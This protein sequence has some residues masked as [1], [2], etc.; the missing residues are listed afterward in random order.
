LRKTPFFRQ[1]WAK[2]AEN[3]D[4][5]I[6]PWWVCAKIAQKIAEPILFF[7][8]Y[9]GS[10][11]F[12]YFL[13]P[14]LYRWATAAPQ[15]NQFLSK[16]IHKLHRGKSSLKIWAESTEIF[17]ETANVKIWPS[18]E[19]TEKVTDPQKMLRNKKLFFYYKYHTIKIENYHKPV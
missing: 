4:H 10:F 11:D 17:K 1:K 5:N 8:G 18:F 16:L 2:I 3:C 13:I 15:P 7:K 6:D 12:V 19:H 14:P 9:P